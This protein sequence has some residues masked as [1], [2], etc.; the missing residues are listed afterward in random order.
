MSDRPAWLPSS[1]QAPPAPFMPAQADG[2]NPAPFQ[3]PWQHKPRQQPPS[4]STQPG[5]APAWLPQPASAPGSA[6]Q[7][8]RWQPS[9]APSTQ[10]APP[11]TSPRRWPP[12]QQQQQQG[13]PAASPTGWPSG[14][15]QQWHGSEEL[16]SN[17]ISPRPAW[18]PQQAQQQP[19]PMQWQGQQQASEHST[20]PSPRPSWEAPVSAT[21][22]RQHPG[23]VDTM[24]FNPNPQ[25]SYAQPSWQPKS[26]F[27]PAPVQSPN[28]SWGSQ[29]P[30]YPAQES[31]GWNSLGDASHV[32]S[33][34]ISNAWEA[35]QMQDAAPMDNG[36]HE[37]TD[38][39]QNQQWDAQP[40]QVRKHSFT[41]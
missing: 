40:E 14:Q 37:Q 39:Q 26:S 32:D 15:Q 23:H 6:S 24:T 30:Q 33:V 31:G 36:S 25:A 13:P 34:P 19:A 27:Q 35:E 28:P 3:P 16:A 5:N 12:G 18:P 41:L 11:A 20:L 22:N 21:Q 1:A 7:T 17:P 9:G 2:S 10:H 4:I 8:P 38:W 29:K